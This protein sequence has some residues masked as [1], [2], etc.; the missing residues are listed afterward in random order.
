MPATTLD[1][2][3]GVSEFDAMVKYDDDYINARGDTIH[4]QDHG[5]DKDDD[6]DEPNES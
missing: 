5:P 1:K 4:L 6:N 3:V 2:M